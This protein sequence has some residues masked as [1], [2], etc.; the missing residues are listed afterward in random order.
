[1]VEQYLMV[2]EFMLKIF[3][4]HL[5]FTSHNADSGDKLLK[6]E[7]I[8]LMREVIKSSSGMGLPTPAN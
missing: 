3:K 1:M 6:E 5:F 4:T 7:F 2:Q 8:P